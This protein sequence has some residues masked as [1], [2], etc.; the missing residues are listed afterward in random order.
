[1]YE[2]LSGPDIENPKT[3]MIVEMCQLALQATLR[4]GVVAEFKEPSAA[5]RN[6]LK[7]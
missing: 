5:N 2:S 6:Q 1:M 4:L 3:F 7:I